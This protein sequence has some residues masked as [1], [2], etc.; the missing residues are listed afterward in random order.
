MAGLGGVFGGLLGNSIL[1]QIVLYQ[2]VGQLI[3]GALAP[4][5]IALRQQSLA[6]FPNVALSPEAAAEAVLRNAMPHDAAANEAAMGGIKRERFDVL[7]L[8][9]GNSLDPQGLAVALRRKLITHDRY[10][11]GIR[12]SRMRDEWADTNAELA[13]GWPSPETAAT[14][15]VEG[16]VDEATARDLYVKFGGDPAY[17]DLVYHVTGSGPSPL[18]AAEMARRGV[19]PWEGIGPLATSFSQAFHESHYRNKWEAGFRALSVYYPP[20]RT[21]TAMVREGSLTP[22]Q[23]SDLLAK[24]GVPP[25]LMAHYLASGSHQK[26]AGTHALA[27]TTVLELYRDRIVSRPQA[28]TMLEALKYTPQEADFI[29]QVADLQVSQRYVNA[30]VSRVHALYVGHKIDQANATAVL[31]QLHLDAAAAAELLTIWTYER[32]ANVVAVTAAQVAGAFHDQILTQE[33][34][35][36]RLEQ[37]GYT[38]ADA[39][40]VLSVHM[41]KALPNKPA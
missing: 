5:D 28:A 36:L 34:A 6:I 3:G 27:Q 11:T 2:V 20:P 23:A 12:Q 4:F 15:L 16:Q 38:P 14:G 10:L 19:I 32:A 22:A 26:L 29:L 24:Q 31:T 17:F 1:Q 8:L 30:A 7:A 40:L 25:E 18:E 39:W 9:A 41:H 35:Q 13:M 33:E 21:I 37:H